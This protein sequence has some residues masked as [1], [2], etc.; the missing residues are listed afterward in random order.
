MARGD[1]RGGEGRGRSR[2]AGRGEKSG[3]T[4]S[5]NRGGEGAV[6]AGAGRGEKS[7]LAGGDNRGG[8]VDSVRRIIQLNRRG[9][10]LGSEE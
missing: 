2:R 6:G 4:R 1:N 9:R 7:G 10:G 8:R 5:D 3:L